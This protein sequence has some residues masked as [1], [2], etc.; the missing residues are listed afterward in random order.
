MII[1]LRLPLKTHQWHFYMHS[2][3]LAWRLY[4][5]S[6]KLKRHALS[7]EKCLTV[8]FFNQRVKKFDL[9]VREAL[10]GRMT[11]AEVCSDPS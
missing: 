3:R 1:F 6:Q 5:N 10:H 7:S 2:T 4:H 11:S 8:A 9:S